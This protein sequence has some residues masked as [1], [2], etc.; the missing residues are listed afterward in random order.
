MSA[1]FSAIIITGALVLPEVIVGMIDASTTRRLASPCTRNSSFTTALGS[2]PILR[3]DHVIGRM[4][5]L[6][7][8]A[9]QLVIGL[10]PVAR[11]HLER[12]IAVER[13][14]VDDAAGDLHAGDEGPTIQFVA[15]VIRPDGRR[16]GGG[17]HRSR[18]GG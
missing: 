1:A 13:L 15:E 17:R 6:P 8:E 4:A 18:N 11:V 5:V 2:W 14:V 12:A 10:A 16:G 3:A 9:Q 7:R